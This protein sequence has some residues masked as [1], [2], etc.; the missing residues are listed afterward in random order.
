MNEVLTLLLALLGGIALGVLFFGGL[1]LTVRK[2]L[3]SKRP[4]LFFMGSLVLRMAIVLV[5]FYYIGAGNWKNMLVGL[6]GF[7]IARIVIT[8]ITKKEK[9]AKNVFIKKVSDED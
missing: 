9:Q 6:G 1:W 3:T 4:T 2:G 5:G 8:R 7:L